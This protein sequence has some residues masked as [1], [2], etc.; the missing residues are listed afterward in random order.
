MKKQLLKKSFPVMLMGGLLTMGFS[1]V[2]A[3]TNPLPT[4]NSVTKLSVNDLNFVQKQQYDKEIANGKEVVD[5]S[6]TKEGFIVITSVSEVPTQN[7]PSTIQRASIQQTMNLASNVYHGW[8][9]VG[10][11]KGHMNITRN[12]STTSINS[13]NITPYSLT[14]TA[15]N[16]HIN[17]GSGSNPAILN[18][19]FTLTIN[20]PA[21]GMQQSKIPFYGTYEIYGNGKLNISIT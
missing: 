5:I 18:H 17:R 16:N 21:W 8:I 14:G 7:S 20:Y 2:A 15:V 9:K 6:Q 19:K 13:W 12:G 1:E 3:D 11:T 4:E 10:S